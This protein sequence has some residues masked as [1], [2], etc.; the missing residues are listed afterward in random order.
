MARPD[1]QRLSV[2]DALV[3]R[4]TLPG[5]THLLISVLTQHLA[6]NSFN[7]AGSAC[8]ATFLMNLATFRCRNRRLK[9]ATLSCLVGI[10]VGDDA[11]E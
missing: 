5:K 2:D 4:P 1:E 3:S 11:Y 6:D 10:E 7:T 8:N 9:S